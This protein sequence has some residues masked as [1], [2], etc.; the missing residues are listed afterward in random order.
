LREVLVDRTSFDSVCW[1]ATRGASSLGIEF[2]FEE[3]MEPPFF[4]EDRDLSSSTKISGCPAVHQ[5]IVPSIRA[6]I[7]S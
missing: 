2:G 1:G 3:K 5:D 6:S 7:A 4:V